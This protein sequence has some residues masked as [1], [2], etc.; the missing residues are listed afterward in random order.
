MINLPDEVWIHILN[1][2]M[3]SIICRQINTTTTTEVDNF[4]RLKYVNN[5]FLRL[6]QPLHVIFI[7]SYFRTFTNDNHLTKMMLHVYLPIE[8]TCKFPPTK[9][10]ILSIRIGYKMMELMIKVPSVKDE[11]LS[12]SMEF[13]WIKG[14]KYRRDIHGWIIKFLQKYLVDTYN[15]LIR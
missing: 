12:N 1:E 15:T 5:Q 7:S 4:M 2:L 13:C 6:I 14:I 10:G 9:E 11:N 8:I 3:I